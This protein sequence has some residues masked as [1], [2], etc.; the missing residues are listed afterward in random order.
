[1]TQTIN[2]NEKIVFIGNWVKALIEAIGTYL[3]IWDIGLHL[4][5]F[6]TLYVP[7]ASINL[8]SLYKLYTVGYPFKL[9]NWCF[10][11]FKHNHFIGSG[12]L[13]DTWKGLCQYKDIWPLWSLLVLLMMIYYVTNVRKDLAYIMHI[14]FYY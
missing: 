6:Q 5:L 4:C 10:N 11:L 1:M 9:R 7:F 12:V 13:C 2:P 14:M 8:V 3:L